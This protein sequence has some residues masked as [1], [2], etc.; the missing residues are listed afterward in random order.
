[1]TLWVVNESPSLKP[2]IQPI[3]KS[4][5]LYIEKYPQS[6]LFSPLSTYSNSAT[7]S[8]DYTTASYPVCL[9]LLLPPHFTDHMCK[10]RQSEPLKMGIR[11]L[12]SLAPN[13]PGV[14]AK[15]DKTPA[16][17]PSPPHAFPQLLLPASLFSSEPQGC[18]YLCAC[19]FLPRN[20]FLQIP[21]S[22]IL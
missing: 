7:A 8:L 16:F 13:P 18:S 11:S 22:F 21:T 12:H 6:C 3:C 10:G 19:L 2:Y 1:M 4:C 14:L 20:I 5:V 9:L 15:P 17:T